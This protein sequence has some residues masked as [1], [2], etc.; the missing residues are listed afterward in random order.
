M[1]LHEGWYSDILFVDDTSERIISKF[2]IHQVFGNH[3][4]INIKCDEIEDTSDEDI[5]IYYC[6][7]YI[8]M[9]GVPENID[10]IK[11]IQTV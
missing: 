6:R 9:Q 11:L 7:Y 4:Q 2:L 10:E 8:Y 1:N 5:L 3:L